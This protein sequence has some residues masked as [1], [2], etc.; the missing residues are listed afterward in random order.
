MIEALYQ[1]SISTRTLANLVKRE[2]QALEPNMDIIEEALLD[3]NILHV[4]ET[5]LHIEGKRAWVP[6]ACTS[7]YTYL[8]PH[9]FVERK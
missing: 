6:I 5:S 1:H 7:K 8:A 2:S 3:S 9:A 4:D